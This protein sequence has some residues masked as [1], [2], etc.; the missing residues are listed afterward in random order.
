M[1]DIYID[2]ACMCAYI[3]VCVCGV[4]VCINTHIPI[5]IH[6]SVDGHL[7]CFYILSIE[8]SYLL[9]NLFELLGLLISLIF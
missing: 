1:V 4:G 7:D 5:F 3:Y 9:L 2:M 8:S 6:S